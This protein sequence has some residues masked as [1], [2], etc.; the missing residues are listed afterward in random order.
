MQKWCGERSAWLLA[1]QIWFA[2]R[3]AREG[4]FGVGLNSKE[5]AGEMMMTNRTVIGQAVMAAVG[6]LALGAFSGETIQI[7]LD[8]KRATAPVGVASDEAGFTLK[9]RADLRNIKKQETLFEIPGAVCVTVKYLEYIESRGEIYRGQNYHRYTVKDGEK[10]YCPILEACITTS[11]EGDIPWNPKWKAR[12]NLDFRVGLPITYMAD[13]EGVHD[14]VLH[15]NGV[16]LTLL[17]GA[18]KDEH[19]TFGDVQWKVGDA[20]SIQSPRAEYAQ[21]SVP[22]LADALPPVSDSR[23]IKA[24]QFFSPEGHNAWVGDTTCYYHD[25]RFHVFYLQDRRNHGSKYCGGHFFA[26]VSTTDMTNWFE[27]PPAAPITEQWETFGTGTPFVQN[28]KLHL[29]YGFHTARLIDQNKTTLAYQNAYIASNGQSRVFAR[30]EVPGYPIGASYSVSDDGIHFKKSYVTLHPSQNPSIYS[31]PDDSL[32]MYAGYGNVK[33]TWTSKKLGEPWVCAVSD[34]PPSETNSFMENWTE[35]QSRFE[36]NGRVYAIA[37]FSGFWCSPDGKTEHFVDWAK[38]GRD[39]YDG[40]NVPMVA[41]YKDNRR[42]LCGWLYGDG[43]WGGQLVLREL[44]QYPNGELGMKWP[45]E[46]VP[47]PEK[48]TELA[49]EI[50]FGWNRASDSYALPTGSVERLL[51]TFTVDPSKV[52]GNEFRRIAVRF[53]NPESPD[54]NG[55][56]SELMFDLRRERVQWNAAFGKDAFAETLPTAP[57]ILL[58]KHNGEVW[59]KNGWLGA[60]IH[61]R[62]GNFALNHVRGM[63]KP[64][65]VK[66]LLYYERKQ[67]STLIDTEIA[68]QRTLVCKRDNMRFSRVS[69]LADTPQDIVIRDVRIG[70]VK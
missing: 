43:G 36:W 12:K 46:L 61:R 26:H 54:W 42:I 14:I 63:D 1:V 57:E 16:C 60:N 41:P 28:G 32:L 23:P 39:I 66:M 31:N 49:G 2:S 35:C 47:R 17:I 9:L 64:F 68:G 58:A 70:E 69:F 20:A 55:Q 15:Y 21:L 13:G 10:W 44:I 37:G 11:T 19:Y 45:T 53:D 6:L 25:G 5:R 51:L 67:L 40:L 18:Y 59:A 33:G 27:H 62:S 24:I 29:S 30:D 50:A 3:F 22:A 34:F 38:E 52:K 7:A 8:A 56:I 65:E 48:M 4:I